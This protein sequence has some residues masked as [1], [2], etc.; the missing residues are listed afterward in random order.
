MQL[1]DFLKT[2]DK[3]EYI[4]LGSAAVFLWIGKPDEIIATLPELDA[5]YTDR[6]KHTILKKERLIARIERNI[7]DPANSWAL[8]MLSGEL[9][10]EK[11]RKAMFEAI[12]E[13]RI[14]FAARQV[15]DVY[16]RRMV[17]P[18]GICVIIDGH[19]Y[20]DFWSFEDMEKNNDQ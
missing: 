19:E 11:D 1:I 4:Y 18:F 14:P 6:L 7:A 2:A 12:L 3:D 9:A 17:E 20:G 13:N 15:K 10:Q 5:D 16:R 8:D